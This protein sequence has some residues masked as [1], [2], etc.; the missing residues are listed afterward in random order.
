MRKLDQRETIWV[1]HENKYILICV[2][3]YK[4]LSMHSAVR[5]WTYNC[6]NLFHI[7]FSPS[8]AAFYY[9]HC[10]RSLMETKWT[11][12]C[13]HT[14]RSVCGDLFRFLIHSLTFWVWEWVELFLCTC[15]N[16]GH[17]T[18]TQTQVLLVDWWECFYVF[19]FLLLSFSF[20]LFLSLS[21]SL[22]LSA[23]NLCSFRTLWSILFHRTS[24]LFPC[25]P[26][27]IL[28]IANGT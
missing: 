28:F 24:Q 22:S 23:T 20:S 1:Y 3:T 9:T 7:P 17:N 14:H 21:L 26:Q 15:D 27:T 10:T 5:P 16:K 19:L 4:S 8:L 25:T 18:H 12:T 11:Y 13:I 6:P 2:H